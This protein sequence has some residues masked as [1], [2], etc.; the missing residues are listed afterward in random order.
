MTV[1]LTVK[2]LPAPSPQN[3]VPDPSQVH[4]RCQLS[5][6]IHTQAVCELLAASLAWPAILYLHGIWSAGWQAAAFLAASEKLE[7]GGTVYQ[8]CPTFWHHW[9]TLKEELS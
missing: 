6:P 8:G 9:A 2:C 4:F 1:V 3:G 5:T 7:A